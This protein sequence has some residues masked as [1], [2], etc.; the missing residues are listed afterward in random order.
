MS[1]LRADP[2]ARTLR[3]THDV[4]GLCWVLLTVPHWVR[5]GVVAFYFVLFLGLLLGPAWSFE[6]NNFC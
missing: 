1:Y 5:S 4:R 3:R 2:H 6:F